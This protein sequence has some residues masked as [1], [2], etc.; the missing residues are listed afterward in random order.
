MKSRLPIRPIVT[1][2]VAVGLS[3]C[4]KPKST[5]PAVVEQPPPSGAVT[6]QD[7]AASRNDVAK[8]PSSPRTVTPV[9]DLPEF[10]LKAY[11]F[12]RKGEAKVVVNGQPSAN[13]IFQHPT[14]LDPSGKD[15]A[16]AT[17]RLGGKYD[18]FEAAVAI[19]DGVQD[20]KG[21]ESPLTFVILGNGE[22][23]WRSRP[24]QKCGEVQKCSV[25]LQ[26][27]DRLTLKVECQGGP[28]YA[29]AVWVEPVV[30]SGTDGKT[31]Q[32]VVVTSTPSTTENG[33]VKADVRTNDPPAASTVGKGNLPNDLAGAARRNPNDRSTVPLRIQPLKWPNPRDSVQLSPLPKPARVLTEKDSLA[34]LVVTYVERSPLYPEYRQTNPLPGGADKKDELM[35]RIKHNPV[36]GEDVTFTAHVRNFGNAASKG[37][38]F[39]W[40]VDGKAASTGQHRQPL[41]VNA[42]A[43]EKFTWKWQTGPHRVRFT[44]EP[45]EPK[46]EFAEFNNT[47]EVATDAWLFALGVQQPIYD[48]FRT[49][50]NLLGTRNFEDWLQWHADRM[51]ELLEKSPGPG[52]PPE[53][54][55]ARIAVARIVVGEASRKLGDEIGYDGRWTFGNGETGRNPDASG[56]A[57]WA[58]APDWGLIHEW[59]HQ[60]ELADEYGITPR[61]GNNLR[62]D[63]G[64][65]YLGEAGSPWEPYMMFTH[66]DTI[67]SP[68]CVAALNYQYGVRR[69]QQ[70]GA[71]Y[72]CIPEQCVYRVL[73]VDGRPVEGADVAFYRSQTNDPKSFDGKTP[74]FRGT[75]DSK[76][77]YLIP[78]LPAPE[79]TTPAG[80]TQRDNPFGAI[81]RS[82]GGAFR[83][84]IR[85]R[86]HLDHDQIDIVTMNLAWFR[87]E[88]K[89]ATFTYQRHIPPLGAPPAPQKVSASIE[90]SVVRLAWEPVA[91][92]AGYNVYYGGRNTFEFVRVSGDLKSTSLAA[93]LPD[94]QLPWEEREHRTMAWSPHDER[95]HR[96]VVTATDAQ[97]RPSA[98]SPVCNIIRLHKPR[99][100]V[101]RP[102]GQRLVRDERY[103]TTLIFKPDGGFFGTTGSP[104]DHV[105]G[106]LD[107]AL[108]GKGRL[109]DSKRGDEYSGDEG[110]LIHESEHYGAAHRQGKKFRWPSGSE[111]GR[112]RKPAGIAA[113]KDN[114]IYI[115]DSGNDRIQVFSETGEFQSVIGQ[116]ELKNPQKVAFASDGRMIVAD[117]GNNRLAIYAPQGNGFRL[118][119]TWRL[120]KPQ[121]VAV[122]AKDRVFA[123]AEGEPSVLMFGKDGK[124]AWRYAGEPHDPHRQP[125]GLAFAPDATL[126][127]TD[128]EAARIRT[129]APPP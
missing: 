115:A 92:A 107:L 83:I 113:G 119:T 37:W 118:A 20:G 64:A 75:T 104:H 23:L 103:T 48:A 14:V 22:E 78:N 86:G 84:V 45:V 43:M 32:P 82:K 128:V 88:K 93:Q 41:A 21:S 16:S 50:P 39:R 8:R 89:K 71:Y 72:F 97:G 100:I 124:I 116:G 15:E 27:V 31:D 110:F 117:Y 76:G 47:R 56:W 52:L 61:L 40:L 126:V 17:Y 129:I 35:S 19:N 106:S 109:L 59:G 68:N 6:A 121:Y 51:N 44:V 98:F 53:G 105:N 63:E 101:V 29:H 122:D 54:C 65:P 79:V 66:G 55:R 95:H 99:G 5:A 34:D 91:G 4:G 87:G 96:F 60:L 73:D 94:P 7:G 85:A 57:R 3:G 12:L 123:T 13:G 112:F 49:S 46:G 120:N 114:R 62:D 70:F 74:I 111:P 127:Y 30:I 108:D 80:F 69:G 18:L 58:S 38:K 24:V 11:M 102:N 9:A 77:E 81:D 28:G 42:E 36:A 67:F 1:V 90:G 26:G 33:T 25:R 10:D 2:L 125:Y